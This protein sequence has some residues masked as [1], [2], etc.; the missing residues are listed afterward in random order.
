M[1]GT[2]DSSKTVVSKSDLGQYYIYIS[3][4]LYIT[5]FIAVHKDLCKL[6]IC[7]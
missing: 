2:K 1:V 7:I 3:L 4:H 6:G 5:A